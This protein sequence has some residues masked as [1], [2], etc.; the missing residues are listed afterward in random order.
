MFARFIPIPQWQLAIGVTEV[1]GNSVDFGG[2]LNRPVANT[3]GHQFTIQS[4][5]DLTRH[6]ALDSALYHFGGIPLDEAFVP[7]Q[8]VPAH[9]RLDIGFSVRGISGL[10]FSVWG[11]DLTTNRHP[12]SLPALFTTQG[13][14]VKRSVGFTLMWESNPKLS[15]E[16]TSASHQVPAT[17]RDDK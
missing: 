9:N 11:R 14:Y 1:R 2:S 6:L 3:P 15:R 4:R 17:A 13:S 12:D 10:T 5:F 8:D 7:S 16:D